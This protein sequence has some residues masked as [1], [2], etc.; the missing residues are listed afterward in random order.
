VAISKRV[1]FEVL[2]R[3][4]F[5][6]RYCGTSATD[7]AGLV[8][9][10]VIPT[11]L[12]GTDEPS[13]LVAACS[14]CNAGKAATAPSAEM[15]DDVFA[16]SLRWAQAMKRAAAEVEERRGEIQRVARA[17]RGE[18]V[19]FGSFSYREPPAGFE[20]SIERWLMAGLSETE[21]VSLVSVAHSR[22]VTASN[23]WRYYA[24][25][26]WTRI[27]QLQE[28]ARELLDTEAVQ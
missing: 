21:M 28:R 12:G 1:R 5:R 15:V 2:R 7:G 17:V 8:V 24:G 4:G 18:W 3:D 19:K 13:N 22:S 10:H 9:D 16:D 6:C 26:C 20:S 27:R 11:A 23:A 14:D 25:C